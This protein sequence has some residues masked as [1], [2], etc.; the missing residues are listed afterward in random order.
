MKKKAII[1]IHGL[2]GGDETWFNLEEK[3]FFKDLLLENKFISNEYECYHFNYESKKTYGEGINF[4]VN[5][6]GDKFFKRK[7]K[8][9]LDLKTITRSLETFLE[10][11]VKK[12]ELDELIFIAHSMG[13]IIAKE[14]ILEKNEDNKIKICFF[15][16]SPQQ[17]SDYALIS[18]LPG[19][20][21]VMEDLTPNSIQII[22]TNQRW[23]N[24]DKLP[25]TFYIEG[26][27]DI[28][29]NEK[30]SYN[31]ENKNRVENIDYKYIRTMDD[32]SSIS[33]PS[34]N[35]DVY[36]IVEKE[37]T[38]NINTDT[39]QEE[40]PYEE[41]NQYDEMIFVLK[42]IAAQVVK[43]TIDLS[44]MSYY[45]FDLAYRELTNSDKKKLAKYSDRIKALYL[46][47]YTLFKTD[48]I[49]DSTGLILE[50][51]DELLN[52]DKDYYHFENDLIKHLEKFGLLHSL[53]NREESIIW[54]KEE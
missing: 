30:S 21:K 40:R 29:V 15:L 6:V 17:G 45:H 13:G 12:D 24:A 47:K 14:Y 11:N 16:A 23:I 39:F 5:L 4:I 9:D 38:Q 27:H 31:Y 32:H 1:F 2:T 52:F 26:N 41:N 48:K 22:E 18:K 3:K 44:K 50:I 28:Y 51:R 7:T 36:R 25:K 54:G 53:A 49:K 42:M 37:I 35:S 46:T 34:K 8:K 33:K 43:Q 20:S 19:T 10:Y